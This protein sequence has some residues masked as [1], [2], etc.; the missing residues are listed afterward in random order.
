MNWKLIL[1]LSVFGLL[2]GIATVFLIPS[3][4][5]PFCWLAIFLVCAFILA[6]NLH[7]NLFV[8]GLLI[9]IVNS[10]WITAAHVLLYEQY[11]ARHAKE[12]AMMNSMSLRL[13]PRLLMLLIGPVV[14]VVSGVVIGLF[15][16]AASKLV[17]PSPRPLT[18]ANV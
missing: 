4:V 2:M 7:A 1:E 15:A 17:K 3:N 18:Q 6:R 11:V 16:W 12:M 8:H 14:G 5:E 13:S 9:G 10:I